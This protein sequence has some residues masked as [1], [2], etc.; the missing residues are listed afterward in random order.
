MRLI[1]IE[2][3]VYAY[4]WMYSSWKVTSHQSNNFIQSLRT[5]MR[6]FIVSYLSY[7]FSL[8]FWQNKTKQKRHWAFK[9]EGWSKYDEHMV[10]VNGK[11]IVVRRVSNAKYI[12]IRLID[13]H[14][15]NKRRE[16]NCSLV[17]THTH[18]WW[19]HSPYS[20]LHFQV[21]SLTSTK[22]EKNNRDAR[23]ASRV[24]FNWI[25]LCRFHQFYHF[26]F[27]VFLLS[28]LSLFQV[29]YLLPSLYICIWL[30]CHPSTAFKAK[31]LTAQRSAAIIS[32]GIL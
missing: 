26:C 32:Y 10:R 12:V 30:Q 2:L 20:E 11:R 25:Q 17:L 9:Q 18:N 16:K 19:L 8:S 5:W 27:S 14:L 6:L 31:S 21:A 28:I 13:V 24:P 23:Y 29:L 22:K 4:K 3:N 7:F 15:T 1:V